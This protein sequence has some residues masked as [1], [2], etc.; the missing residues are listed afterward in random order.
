MGFYR[1]QLLPRLVDATCRTSRAEPYRR[2]VTAGLHGDVVEIGFGSGL[3]LP[4]Q[5]SA[6][7]SV[8]AIEPSDVA[9]RKAAG[10]IGECPIR[11]ERAGIDAQ[12]LPEGDQAFDCALSTW[13]LCT[14]PD[15]ATALAEIRRVLRPGGTFHFVE[16]GLA[17]DPE[18]VRWQR[19]LE[20]LQKRVFGGCHV[21]RPIVG[22]VER[23][24]F[25]VAG[26]DTFY[27]PGAP[28]WLGYSSLGVAR[29]R[30]SP[31][32]LTRNG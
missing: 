4:Y 22:L 16:H 23:A 7:T 6:V 27:Q 25:E 8:T 32:R 13:T 28:R 2:R 12:R 14:V 18:V 19:R 3:N 5:P 29:D 9:W 17:P 15:P 24:G 31:K 21:T 26:L 1:T 10:R 20:P 30:G 11:V